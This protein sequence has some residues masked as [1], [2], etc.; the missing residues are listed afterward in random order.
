[1]PDV[2][3][4]VP[5]LVCMGVDFVICGVLYKAFSTTNSILRDLS[6]SPQIPI[7]DNLRTVIENHAASVPS[8][9]ASSYTIPYAVVR[10]DV[11]PLGKTVCSSYST[12]MVGI[13][14][15]LKQMRK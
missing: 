1:M 4:F 8:G 5:E 12:D 11:S 9:D 14:T 2:G 15:S 3:D 6:G 10:G 13:T 7:D